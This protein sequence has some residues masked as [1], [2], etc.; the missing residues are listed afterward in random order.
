MYYFLTC[1]GY[2]ILGVKRERPFLWPPGIWFFPW[3]G[4]VGGGFAF[5]GFVF[6]IARAAWGFL[7]LETMNTWLQKKKKKSLNSIHHWLCQSTNNLRVYWQKFLTISNCLLYCL[8]NSIDIT[9]H[10]T[11]LRILLMKLVFHQRPTIFNWIKIW[12][13][14]RNVYKSNSLLSEPSPKWQVSLSIVN[15]KKYLLLSNLFPDILLYP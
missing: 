12:W 15:D 14:R 8:L 7:Y 11:E 4:E 9:L 1:L 3:R 13:I 10:N 2:I 6:S 5:I